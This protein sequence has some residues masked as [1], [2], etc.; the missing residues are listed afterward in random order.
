MKS[1]TLDFRTGG[2]QLRQLMAIARRAV[3]RNQAPMV[4]ISATELAERDAAY[5]L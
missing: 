4:S 5:V 2:R 1:K 3:P